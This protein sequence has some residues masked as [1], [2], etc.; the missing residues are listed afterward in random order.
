MNENLINQLMGMLSNVEDKKMAQS[1]NKA[2]DILKNHDIG[3]IKNA[4]INQ[5]FS[6]ISEIPDNINFDMDKMIDS[7]PD[8]KKKA[9]NDKF[10][11]P[12]FQK[13]LKTDKDK[14]I[15]LLMKSI[16]E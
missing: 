9:L 14:A 8:S 11:S 5:D 10:N 3:E 16:S 1:V 15:Q 7:L 2:I 12:E 4:I 6:K 13:A